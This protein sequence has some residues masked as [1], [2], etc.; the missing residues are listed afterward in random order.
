MAFECDLS[1]GGHNVPTPS[2]SP[3]NTEKNIVPPAAPLGLTENMCGQ[4]LI[5]TQLLK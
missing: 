2:R 4:P 5:E 1:A 3:Q